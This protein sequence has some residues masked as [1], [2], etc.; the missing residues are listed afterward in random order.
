MGESLPRPSDLIYLLFSLPFSRNKVT[1]LAIFN[2]MGVDDRLYALV[3]G[4][5]ML[6]DAVAIVLYRSI[7]EYKPEL[8]NEL[9]VGSF[10]YSIWVFLVSR[11]CDQISSK[12]NAALFEGGC[13]RSFLSLSHS[14]TPVPVSLFAA[15]YYRLLCLWHAR[16]HAV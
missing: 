9:S 4:E 3:F 1:V 6:N 7:S 13:A 11:S 8:N 14:L 2:D 10:F 16:W 12:Y 15:D 5:S